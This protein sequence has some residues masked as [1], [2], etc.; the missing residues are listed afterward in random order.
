MVSTLPSLVARGRHIEW[1]GER[2]VV[3]VSATRWPRICV[4]RPHTTVSNWNCIICK[5]AAA[6]GKEKCKKRNP[7]LMHGAHTHTHT[8]TYTGARSTISKSIKYAFRRRKTFTCIQRIGNLTRSAPDDDNLKNIQIKIYIESSWYV[9]ARRCRVRVGW[10]DSPLWHCS[11]TR[12]CCHWPTGA[13]ARVHRKPIYFVLLWVASQTRHYSIHWDI[14][15]R[16]LCSLDTISLMHTHTHYEGTS[17]K[18]KF[19][20]PHT[21]TP[22]SFFYLVSIP[23][24]YLK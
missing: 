22:R 7:H 10:R 3:T 24:V 21:L 11:L 8:H 12:C 18:Q 14:E 19:Y 9:S 13:T 16:P 5:V 15:Q 17:A 23:F 4:A 20:F 6:N 1:I 2:I